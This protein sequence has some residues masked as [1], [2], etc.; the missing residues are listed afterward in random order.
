MN[1][2][3]IVTSEPRILSGSTHADRE[4]R[5][6]RLADK[7]VTFVSEAVPLLIQVRRDFLDKDRDEVIYNCRTF[8]EYCT[9]VLRYSESHIRRLIAGHNP[10][11]KKFDGS[12]NRQPALLEDD[13]RT[14]E[15][16]MWDSGTA[17]K[18]LE[19]D[20]VLFGLYIAQTR[21]VDMLEA[22]DDMKW[23]FDAISLEG[24][25]YSHLEAS[26]VDEDAWTRNNEE[27]Y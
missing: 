22:T 8:T 19:H 7:F 23:L 1:D 14:V 3:A 10:A 25:I 11:T 4:A 17:Q 12:K 5:A 6:Q 15:E 27:D 9:T 13:Q 21:C 24:K 26:H 18:T 2:M 20:P 16:R